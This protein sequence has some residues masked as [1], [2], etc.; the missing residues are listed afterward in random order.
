MSPREFYDRKLEK[1]ILIL[2]NR[3]IQECNKKPLDVVMNSIIIYNRPNPYIP[4]LISS[5]VRDK[6]KNYLIC[7]K[8][9]LI[10]K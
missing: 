9:F 3:S 5:D 4:R 8:K 7:I 1:E 10:A 6:K 2:L